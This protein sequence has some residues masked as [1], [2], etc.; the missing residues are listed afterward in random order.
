MI[1]SSS[2]LRDDLSEA[3]HRFILDAVARNNNSLENLEV[4]KYFDCGESVL[5][6]CCRLKPNLV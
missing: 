4:R 6:V 2:G 3:V 5:I 1:F